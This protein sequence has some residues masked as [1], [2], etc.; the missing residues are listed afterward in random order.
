M[1]QS[2]VSNETREFLKVEENRRELKRA[3]S[4]VLILGIALGISNSI[5]KTVGRSVKER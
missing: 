1:R 5:Q 2:R 4:T 3:I